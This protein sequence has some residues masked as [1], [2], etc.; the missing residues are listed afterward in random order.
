MMVGREAETVE[1]KREEVQGEGGKGEMEH[2][3]AQTAAWPAQAMMAA[4]RAAR[5][6]VAERV[7]V[8]PNRSQ[9]RAA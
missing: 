2:V 9:T 1:E 6:A 5:L 7:A 3:A 4:R 8:D